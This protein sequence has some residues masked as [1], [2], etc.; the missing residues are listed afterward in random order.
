MLYGSK[1]IISRSGSKMH[2]ELIIIEHK[3]A[4]I[5][6]WA[7]DPDDWIV[8]SDKHPGFPALRWA[9]RMLELHNRGADDRASPALKTIR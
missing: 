4:I 9:E 1:K 3:N 5:V 7:D 2:D 6:A 8:R